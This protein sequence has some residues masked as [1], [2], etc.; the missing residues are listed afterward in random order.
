MRKE[1]KR[2]VKNRE[3]VIY[4]FNTV[5]GL[6]YLTKLSKLVGKSFGVLGKAKAENKEIDFDLLVES[7]TEKLDESTV[8]FIQDLMSCVMFQGKRVSDIFDAHFQSDYLTLFDLVKEVLEVNF[9]DFLLGMLER[10]GVVHQE[11]QK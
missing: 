3:Y 7:F 6:K 5:D 1:V 10:V 11:K 9:K 4:Q 8:D 2:V